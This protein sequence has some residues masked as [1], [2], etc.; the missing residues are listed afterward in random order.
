MIERNFLI[1]VEGRKDSG[2]VGNLLKLLFKNIV[3][4]KTNEKFF[5]NIQVKIIKDSTSEIGS[6]LENRY[7]Q[8]EIK[9][10]NSNSEEIITNIYIKRATSQNIKTFNEDIKN[11]IGMSY[12]LEKIYNLKNLTYAYSIFDFDPGSTT[13]VQLEEYFDL[14]ENLDNFYPIINYPGIEA[15]EIHINYSKIFENFNKIKLEFKDQDFTNNF[16]IDDFEMIGLIFLKRVENI[17]KIIKAF[18]K[19]INRFFKNSNLNNLSL[20]QNLKNYFKYLKIADINTDNFQVLDEQKDI[21]NKIVSVEKFLLISF[22]ISVFE[23][24]C[25]WIIDED[26]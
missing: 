23:N 13:D 2:T 18:Q 21:F 24:I 17:S 20:E 1:L 10:I 19:Q 14:K 6:I 16:Y 5:N 4:L 26:E 22:T 7:E 12:S 3:I 15:Q 25:E 8:L 9:S 11:N